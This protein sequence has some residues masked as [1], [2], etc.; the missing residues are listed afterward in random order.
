MLVRNPAAPQHWLR[1]G[2]RLLE[3]DQPAKARYC[4]E[5]ATALAPHSPPVLLEAAAF[6]Y[7]TGLR[8]QGLERMSRVLATTRAYDDVIFAFYGRAVETATVL[9]E[10]LPS[11]PSAARSYFLYRLGDRDE[12]GTRL[13]WD[14]LLRHQYADDSTL[15]RYLRHL[16][17]QSRHDEAAAVFQSYLSPAETPSGGERVTH[18]GFE[19]ESTGALLDWIIMPSPHADVRRDAASPHQGRWS[20]RVEFDGAA[21]LEYRHVAQQVVV[22][23]GLWKL[24][25]WVRTQNITSDQGI[26]LSIF[27]SNPKPNWQAWTDTVRGDSAWRLLEST[28]SVPPSTHLVR[29]E[30]VRR[31]SRKLDNKLGGVAWIDDVSLTPLTPE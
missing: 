10:G 1:M 14:W 20:L 9:R 26:G 13:T 23:P 25:A 2:H 30:I 16:I 8:F 24:R 17:E 29:I 28:V 3:A 22:T 7:A 18:G 11:D 31:P 6:F 5:R 27:E 15:R 21:N 19:A 12:P 4:I